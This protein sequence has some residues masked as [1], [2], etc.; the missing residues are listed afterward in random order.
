MEEVQKS[1]KTKKTENQ[2]AKDDIDK[3]NPIL[4]SYANIAKKA[5]KNA[6]AKLKAN[7]QKISKPD[8]FNNI[9]PPY[10]R[11]KDSRPLHFTQNG[12][13]LQYFTKNE[14]IKLNLKTLQI[15]KR[16]PLRGSLSPLF[17]DYKNWSS[18]SSRVMVLRARKLTFD[19]N[20]SYRDQTSEEAFI[21]NTRTGEYIEI[22]KNL[23]NRFQKKQTDLS[24]EIMIECFNPINVNEIIIR[25]VIKRSERRDRGGW[26]G[27]QSWQFQKEN[28]F[29]WNY[30]IKSSRPFS[31]DIPFSGFSILYLGQFILVV[32]QVDK[33]HGTS[34]GNKN[35]VNINYLCIYLAKGF[36]KVMCLKSGVMQS[37]SEYNYSR[38]N[39]RYE[40]YSR[41]VTDRGNKLCLKFQDKA[42]FVLDILKRELKTD[43]LTYQKTKNTIAVCPESLKDHFDLKVTKDKLQ[44]FT[45]YRTNN[46]CVELTEAIGNRFRVFQGSDVIVEIKGNKKLKS[47]RRKLT[48]EV[49]SKSKKKKK[50]DKKKNKGPA[51]DIKR[52][53]FFIEDTFFL[54]Q[55]L[56]S[57]R[58]N[59]SHINEE[60]NKIY[61][62][63][64]L[65][66][67][68]VHSESNR[69]KDPD[70]TESYCYVI[71][72][73]N[74]KTWV[75]ENIILFSKDL[76]PNENW[77]Y[78]LRKDNSAL[79]NGYYYN[80]PKD[81]R[82]INS[83]IPNNRFLI[84]RFGMGNSRNRLGRLIFILIDVG[85][86]EMSYI[87]FKFDNYHPI[88]EGITRKYTC[89]FPDFYY[90][91]DDI[92]INSIKMRMKNEFYGNC[93]IFD[94][95]TKSFTSLDKQFEIYLD[96]NKGRN[97]KKK[98][99]IEKSTKQD[100]SHLKY[101]VTRER[102]KISLEFKSGEEITN[103]MIILGSNK[104]T[105]EFKDGSYKICQSD[106]FEPNLKQNY[107]LI[108][109]QE[110]RKDFM[111]QAGIKEQQNGGYYYNRNLKSKLLK[112][113]F[114]KEE[115]KAEFFIQA[116][117]HQI[118]GYSYP[119]EG[120]Q[121]C[122]LPIIRVKIDLEKFAQS[123]NKAIEYESTFIKAYDMPFWVVRK[124]LV[125]DG[126]RAIGHLFNG[127]FLNFRNGEI[128]CRNFDEE[129]KDLYKRLDNLD[130]SDFVE[131]IVRVLSLGYRF[132]RL[133]GLLGI[134]NILDELKE[135]W[136]GGRAYYD[137][138]FVEEE[139][140]IPGN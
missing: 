38:Y 76:R 5:L 66:P 116:F 105:L 57:D 53:T 101:N 10:I 114:S 94:L 40:I 120:F 28:M 131:V 133:V 25:E 14:Y 113:N 87:T 29:S 103:G 59:F 118:C 50:K 107:E 136:A 134:G 85:S 44:G 47:H 45:V 3:A 74:T 86:G 92:V 35:D 18:D 137:L 23:K 82:E 110:L 58:T 99:K 73:Y 52:I 54:T 95:K 93:D 32:N 63:E 91:Q 62:T 129:L 42:F 31:M 75:L 139:L 26:V 123:S 88:P 48:I 71:K 100:F 16:L 89:E 79:F 84:Q 21:F 126:N 22:A 69:V 19:K 61:V 119:R 24:S 115:K 46:R 41:F 51:K 124:A 15:D 72:T 122:I 20:Q 49:K 56:S 112:V 34:H 117:E 135:D 130:E 132:K 64:I 43:Q 39:N 77:R 128:L 68:K 17:Y 121:I 67:K 106:A 11:S 33:R 83:T 6:T 80:Q 111:G 60:K 70:T 37:S 7:F 30:I 65:N 108:L 109:L 27:W 2:N 9:P 12:S 1:A 81:S 98:K 90:N 104:F 138:M 96:S 97:K 125:N 8:F 4:P 55:E 127:V 36:R 78:F 140:M 102:K 13:H